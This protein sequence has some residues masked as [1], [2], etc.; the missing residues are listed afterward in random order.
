ME[1]ESD[2]TAKEGWAQPEE[3]GY[4]ALSKEDIIGSVR[5]SVQNVLSDVDEAQR[6]PPDRYKLGEE[7]IAGAL[8]MKF[9]LYGFYLENDIKQLYYVNESDSNLYRTVTYILVDGEWKRAGESN[10]MIHV[11][12]RS[13]IDRTT[14]STE[15]QRIASVKILW[16]QF[17][18]N[19]FYGAVLI[20]SDTACIVALAGVSIIDKDDCSNQ[21]LDKSFNKM[22]DGHLVEN[23]QIRGVIKEDES[24]TAEDSYGTEN[25]TPE[26]YYSVASDR[27]SDGSQPSYGNIADMESYQENP[28]SSGDIRKIVKNTIHYFLSSAAYDKTDTP[29][30]R[31]LYEKLKYNRLAMTDYSIQHPEMTKNVE[32]EIDKLKQRVVDS[33]IHLNNPGQN[34]DISGA[35]NVAFDQEIESMSDWGSY[36]ENVDKLNFYYAEGPLVIIYVKDLLLKYSGPTLDTFLGKVRGKISAIRST[37]K[38]AS[39]EHSFKK[40]KGGNNKKITKKMTPNKPKTKKTKNQNKPKKTK[41]NNKN[42]NNNKKKNKKLNYSAKRK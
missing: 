36:N 18:I 32:N 3:D 11:M 12:E 30:K 2:A 28:Y 33:L 7:D 22:L 1:T 16:T 20:Q 10:W 4:R 35:V 31:Y 9:K 39:S 24:Q 42:K 25:L 17:N 19:G 23:S 15:S 5:V 26:S 37:S 21:S 29:L 13:E 34:I 40:S 6:T 8:Q 14:V 27:S 38:N 41:K